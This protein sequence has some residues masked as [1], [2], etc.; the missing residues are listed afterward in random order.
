MSSFLDE[1]KQKLKSGS[2]NAELKIITNGH[3]SQRSSTGIQWGKI[4]GILGA[5]AVI[6]MLIVGIMLF[7]NNEKEKNLNVVHKT[8]APSSLNKNNKEEED[9][10]VTDLDFEQVSTASERIQTKKRPANIDPN[11]TLL[12]ELL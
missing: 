1:L 10:P 5:V 4:L 2:A 12:S 3:K 8:P 9:D 6:V 11:F 7:L